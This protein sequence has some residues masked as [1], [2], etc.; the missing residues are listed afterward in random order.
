[1][2]IDVTKNFQLNFYKLKEQQKGKPNNCELMKRVEMPEH[3]F[4]RMMDE[5]KRLP[6]REMVLLAPI[7]L[8]LNL[9]EASTLVSLAGYAYSPYFEYDKKLKDA[10]E[11]RQ[12]D[13]DKIQ[14]EIGTL[15]EKNRP[16]WYKRN[17]KK[18]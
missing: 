12:Y 3:T 18:V 9:D 10:L 17:E 6:E 4:Y 1:M 5:N 8:R 13:F 16:D 15:E 11:K 2:K 7:M 14:E